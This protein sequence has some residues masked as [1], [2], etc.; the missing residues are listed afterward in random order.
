MK[1]RREADILLEIHLK[2]LFGEAVPEHLF[3]SERKWRF[4]CAVPSIMLACEIE[5]GI[6]PFRD[7]NPKSQTFGQLVERGRH[8]RGQG[9]QE[10]LDKYNSAASL[11]WVVFR[12]SV[13]DVITGR[14]LEPLKQWRGLLA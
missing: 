8:S 13:K 7:K 3:H 14:D 10:D 5:G 4:D 9:Y 2:E 12:F 6:H 11:G 1:V